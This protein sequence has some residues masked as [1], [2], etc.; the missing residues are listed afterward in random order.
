MA[1]PASA[2][3]S[4]REVGE[5]EADSFFVRFLSGVERML[6]P[7]EYALLLQLMP[8]GG[9]ASAL[10]AYE[11]L[12]ASG[13]VDGFLITDPEL[14]DP[15]FPLL[16]AVGLPVVVA[17]RPDSDS[18]L[19]W[20]ETEHDR[21]AVA[22]V[23][24]LVGLGHERIAFL[25]GSPT[26]E[27]VQRRLA[28]WREALSVAGLDPGPVAFADGDLGAAVPVVLEGGSTAVVCTSD[29]LALALVA[30]ARARGTA[31]PQ[32][33]SVTGFDDSLP[34]TLSSPALTSVRVD[35]AEFGAAATATLLAVL[36]G[37]ETPTYQPSLPVLEV[38]AST[39]PAGRK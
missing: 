8:S 19:P 33:L 36:S 15:R 34:A 13:R 21:G 4:A 18:P 39:S 23:E 26:Y 10:R 11:R 31:V 27:P 14:E 16:E 1:G 20:L 25:G 9:A 3:R 22:A 6:A 2:S 17:G 35:Y 37:A 32:D 30:A 7:A 12:A 38:R 24:H 28:R 5:L 29:T